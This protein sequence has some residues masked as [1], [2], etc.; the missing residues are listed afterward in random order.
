[1]SKINPYDLPSEE[2]RSIRIVLKNI[3]WDTNTSSGYHDYI[4]NK[5]PST[6][7]IPVD[8]NLPEEEMVAAAVD[9]ASGAWGFCITDCDVEPIDYDSPKADDSY[10]SGDSLSDTLDYEGEIY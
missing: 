10:A 5:L 7:S 9:S 6:M 4:N 1:M 8:S 2:E 3:K